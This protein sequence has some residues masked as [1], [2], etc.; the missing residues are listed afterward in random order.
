MMR[1]L[2]IIVSIIA[3]AFALRNAAISG[4]YH[5]VP[6]IGARNHSGIDPVD[7]FGFAGRR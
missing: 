2:I 1:D 5:T 4:G 6:G 7:V 3:A